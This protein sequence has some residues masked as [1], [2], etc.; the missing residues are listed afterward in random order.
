MKGRKSLLEAISTNYRVFKSAPDKL[1][2]D[3]KFVRSAYY[4][5]SKIAT[6]YRECSCPEDEKI[7]ALIKQ[8]Q[9]ENKRQK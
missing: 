6:L 8:V 1:K 4:A 2:Q 3:I 9:E 7:K 5:N